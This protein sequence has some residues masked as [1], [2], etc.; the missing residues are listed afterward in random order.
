M[1][2]F[3]S[4]LFRFRGGLG[5]GFWTK[6]ARTF[7]WC[8][9][10]ASM[11]ASCSS[12][13]KLWRA[14]SKFA[15]LLSSSLIRTLSDFGSSSFSNFTGCKNNFGRGEGKIGWPLS[16]WRAFWRQSF[17]VTVLYGMAILPSTKLTFFFGFSRQ[18]RA[19]GKCAARIRCTCSSECLL[20]ILV[21]LNETRGLLRGSACI[22]IVWVT[23]RR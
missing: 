23:K 8:C 20:G 12:K 5:A 21:T 11:G 13:F 19:P 14:D 2:G 17:S 18:T 22:C 16:V 4:C 6:D 15:I 10:G 9:K 3:W 7:N 1:T